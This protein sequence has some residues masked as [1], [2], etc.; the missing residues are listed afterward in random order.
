DQG[1]VRHIRIIPAVLPD[2]AAGHFRGNLPLQ[3]LQLQAGI[4]FSGAGDG[5]GIYW[6]F[7]VCEPSYAVK[8]EFCYFF[9]ISYTEKSELEAKEVILKSIET[10]AKPAI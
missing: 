1:L 8:D 10:S 7:G 4:Y 9:V 5:K 6:I 3:H 2:G